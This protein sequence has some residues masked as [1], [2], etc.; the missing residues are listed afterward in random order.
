MDDLRAK[1][2][3][4]ADNYNQS[5][6]SKLTDISRTRVYRILR[7]AGVK[8]QDTRGRKRGPLEKGVC[9]SCKTEFTLDPNQKTHR[10]KG[11]QP[12]CSPECLHKRRVDWAKSYEGYKR[13]PEANRWKHGMYSNESREASKL[14]AAINRHVATINKHVKEGASI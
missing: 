4:L 5:E 1:V 9:P 13:G 11:Q 14:I 2:I 10:E 3:S 12:C 8:T 7:A 6:I